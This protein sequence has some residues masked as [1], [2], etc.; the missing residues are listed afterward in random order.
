MQRRGSVRGPYR[1]F[2]SRPAFATTFEKNMRPTRGQYLFTKSR[3]LQVAFGL[4]FVVVPLWFA[5]VVAAVL[6]RVY[7][8][9]LDI[10]NLLR[11]AFFVIVALLL[12]F[13]VAL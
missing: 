8:P 12:A 4:L 13:L 3:P 10:W 11:L 1:T 7:Q 9:L 2:S 6:A 5:Y